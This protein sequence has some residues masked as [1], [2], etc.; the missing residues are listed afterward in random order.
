M[1]RRDSNKT[2]GRVAAETT[3]STGYAMIMGEITTGSSYIDIPKIARD[4]ISEIGYDRSEY[5]FD[6]HTCAIM[7]AADEQSSDI[8]MG[9]DDAL[10]HK[11]GTM[12]D[13]LEAIEQV[14][15]E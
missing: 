10:E 1:N 13:D 8:A 12:K 4:V 9:V 15:R 11:E 2:H 5:G 7:T 6:G 14:T 3:V